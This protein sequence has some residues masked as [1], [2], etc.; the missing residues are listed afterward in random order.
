MSE[1]QSW[2][3]LGRREGARSQ[4]NTVEPG[5]HLFHLGSILWRG[6]N[7]QT[8]WEGYREDMFSARG[9]SRNILLQRSW[10]YR[11]GVSKLEPVGPL[12]LLTVLRRGVEG[13]KW[14][15]GTLPWSLLLSCAGWGYLWVH[16][17]SLR[18]YWQVS[19]PAE[20]LMTLV[21][22]HHYRM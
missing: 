4:S 11:A 16:T 6:N 17:L 8:T 7:D 9:R 19:R 20:G 10:E 1:I 21:R 5:E 15:R 22:T 18:L 2:V 13:S 3:F 14:V 12:F